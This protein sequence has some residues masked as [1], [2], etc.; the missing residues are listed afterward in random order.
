MRL[1]EK[2]KFFIVDMDGTFYLGNNIIPGAD[3]ALRAVQESGRDYYFFSN[4][5]SHSVETCRS[6]LERIGFPVPADKVIL[7]TFVAGRFLLREYPGKPV[8]LLGNSNLYALFRSMGVPIATGETDAQIVMLGF[9]TDLT[10]ARIRT[11]C[12]LIRAGKPFFATHPDVNCPVPGGFIPDAG[13][14]IEMFYASTGVRPRILGKPMTASVD[15]LTRRLLCERDELAF[16][17]DRLET[18]IR[19]GTDHNIPTVLVLSGATT[20]EMAQRSS[21]RPTLI[22][23][24]LAELPRYLPPYFC[25]NT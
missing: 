10:Y 4:N 11:A 17:G 21:I 9:D 19:I 7:S 16:I 23:S 25:Q 13:A 15:Y 2:T 20:A 1:F 5:S 24:S 18:D 6:R 12:D 3:D 22:L 14:M 8:Y